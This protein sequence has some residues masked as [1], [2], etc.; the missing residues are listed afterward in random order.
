VGASVKETDKP[1]PSPGLQV[2]LA[3][4]KGSP[5]VTTLA[6]TV[7]L[8]WPNP[9]LVGELDPA[10]G[11]LAGRLP[12]ERSGGLAALAAA[13]RHT[14]DWEQLASHAKPA[15]EL[16]SILL[17]PADPVVSRGAAGVL[18][19][20]LPAAARSEGV[21][22]LWDLGR[23]DPAS[24]GWETAAGCDLVAIVLRPAA[25]DIAHAVRPIVDLG[26]AGIPVGL[27][28]A[29]AHR[30][31]R[32]HQDGHIAEAISERVGHRVAIL[33][34]VPFDPLGVAMAE[35]LMAHWAGRCSLGAS[36]R[37]VLEGIVN[38]T[39]RAGE[40]RKIGGTW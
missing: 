21:A 6:L 19:S 17:G 3:S 23:L 34:R 26:E 10:G 36:V 2:A 8:V 38:A 30:G 4:A 39:S 37:A 5:G 25:G 40:A 29:S 31:R 33:G 13:G 24:P 32:A 7:G 15:T 12:L 9:V 28:V 14:I 18:A 20:A 1:V 16:C 22:G 27:V 35:R 11:D